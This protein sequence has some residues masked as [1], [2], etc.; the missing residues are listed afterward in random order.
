MIEVALGWSLK[1]PWNSKA[2]D[3]VWFLL[4]SWFKVYVQATQN[5]V[6]C[7]RREML[8]HNS[9]KKRRN[10]KKAEILGHFY[11]TF[12]NCFIH[13]SLLFSD[14]FSSVTQ[15]CQTLCDPMNC[16]TPGF[17][18]HHHL[19]EFTQTHMHRVSMPSSHLILCRPILLL[20]PIPPS[21]RVFSNESTLPM[22]WPKY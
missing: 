22:R 15:L 21:I 6:E 8:P 20:P 1:K 11:W 2:T 7:Q 14:Q 17:P 5:G 10:T 4:W 13:L 16:S 9:T 19:L 12:T 3:L 18:V